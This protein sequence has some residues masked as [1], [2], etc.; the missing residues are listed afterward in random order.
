MKKRGYFIGLILATWM[1]FPST[2][3]AACDYSEQ[4][5][6]SSEATNVRAEYEVKNITIDRETMKEVT[7]VNAGE[8]NQDSPYLST[9]VVDVSL[10]N[11]TDNLYVHLTEN[12]YTDDIYYED[13]D[14]GVY[15]FRVDD[16][17]NIHEYSFEIYATDSN[18]VGSALRS[19][20]MKTPKY[21]PLHDLSACLDSNEYYCQMFVDYEI[22]ISESEVL[23]RYSEQETRH[24]EAVEDSTKNFWEKNKNIIIISGIV[25]L[26]LGAATFVVITITRKKSRV[27]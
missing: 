3:L 26:G 18:C 15:T 16:V 2:I 4:V 22:N 27:I 10:Y 14:D 8:F 23:K 5:K 17:D 13:T 20:K 24:S 25:I 6:L 9:W 1:L 19:V 12:N 7:G 11:I 21:N